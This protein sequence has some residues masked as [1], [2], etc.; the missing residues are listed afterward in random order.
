M[1]RLG[2]LSSGNLATLIRK[3]VLRMLTWSCPTN[4]SLAINMLKDE[5]TLVNSLGTEE[6]EENKRRRDEVIVLELIDETRK[7]RVLTKGRA[8]W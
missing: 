6:D 7:S 3:E 8:D 4:K 2:L 1:V 5:S